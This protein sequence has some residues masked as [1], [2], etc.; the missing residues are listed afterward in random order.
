MNGIY[1]AM[2]DGVVKGNKSATS[3]GVILCNGG[4]IRSLRL[5]FPPRHAVIRVAAAFLSG[6]SLK[7]I[8]MNGAGATAATDVAN[9]PAVMSILPSRYLQGGVDNE[10]YATCDGC[11]C[12]PDKGSNNTCPL[13]PPQTLPDFP[14]APWI[15]NLNALQLDN[16][17]SLNCNPYDDESCDTEPPLVSGNACVWE[18]V[19]KDGV[20]EGAIVNS[21]SCANYY[22]YKL[23]TVPET[24]DEA[25]AM[26]MQVTHTGA[27]GLCSTFQDWSVYMTV[28]DLT[29]VGSRCGSRFLV[30]QTLGIQCFMD[31]G[32]TEGCANIWGWNSFYT[33]R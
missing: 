29:E 23:T 27:C 31:T 25:T 5:D 26:G 32:F 10:T 17:L 7:Y 6:V 18:V 15:D 3:G 12:I 28:P 9:F 22:T 16:P 4:T 30:N 21:T 2:F 33:S 1:K 14:Q 8:S 19:I 11:W 24:F 20:D 13:D